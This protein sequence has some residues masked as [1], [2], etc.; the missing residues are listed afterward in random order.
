MKLKSLLREQNLETLREIAAFWEIHPPQESQT[1]GG[2]ESREAQADEGPVSTIDAQALRDH[3]Y[4]RLQSSAHFQQAFE[5]L[6]KAQADIVY[7]LAIHGGNLAH[8]E[9]RRRCFA[10]SSA[11]EMCE[12]M[13]QLQRRG[14]VFR[15]EWADVEGKPVVYGLPE[16]YLKLIDLPHFWRGHLGRLLRN[17]PSEQLGRI[18][19][20]GL[21]L[22]K[23]H[24][25]R[26]RLIH[27]IRTALTDPDRLR[28]YVDALSEEER[29]VLFLILQRRGVC[30]Y[31]ELVDLVQRRRPETARAEALGHLVD[32][33]GLLFDSTHKSSKYQNLLRVPRDLYYIMMNHFERDQRGLHDLDAIGR[34]RPEE[35][36]RTILDNGIAILRDLV[37][38]VGYVE[39]H[40]VR[41]LGNGGI[42]KNDLKKILSRLSAHKTL[43]YAQ[44]LA[45]YAIRH[46]FLVPTGDHFSVTE[47]FRRSL[48][49]SRAFYADIYTSW[50][51]GTEWNEEYVEGDCVHADAPPGNLIHI[52]ALRR[53]VLRNL[54]EIPFEAWIDGPRF[55]ESLLAQI[56]V[57]IPHRGGKARKDKQNRIN[58]LVIESILCE[59]L[60]WM[61]L[62]SLGLHEETRLEQ[63]GNRREV[64][65]IDKNGSRS[66]HDQ[67]FNYNPR[68]LLPEAYRFHFQINGLGRSILGCGTEQSREVLAESE[69]LNL[70]FRDDMVQFTVLPNLDVVAP[71]DLNLERF[72]RLRQFAEVRHIDVMSIMAITRNSVRAAMDHGMSAE[73]IL[74][75]LDASCPSG[76]PQTVRH[77]VDECNMRYGEVTLGYAGGYI[78]VSDVVRLE[79]LRKN[80]TLTPHIKDIIDDRV[81]L[82]TRD[83][84]VPHIARELKKMGMMPALD[85]QNVYKTSEGRLHFSLNADD[86][87]AL[88]AVVKFAVR[89][90]E[91]MDADLT[92]G[93]ARPLLHSLAP[94]SQGHLNVQETQEKM[95]ERFAANFEAGL[96][97]KTD[98][99]T[100]KY[101]SQMRQ[102]LSNHSPSGERHPY[103]GV[104]PATRRADIRKLIHFAIDR[105]T[106]V[107][108]RYLS[109]TKEETVEEVRPESI[110]GDR[111]HAFCES[112][113]AYC[114]YRLSRIQWASID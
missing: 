62:I 16:P 73:D 74:E 70:P 75:F 97:K 38:F 27:E 56:E 30:L 82:L 28:G 78:R 9:L 71:P 80:K 21:N 95:A 34:V 66:R 3:L 81:V 12:A 79:D 61:G 108:L 15:E 90:E 92:E 59:S 29:E 4:P 52:R 19:S 1:Q 113:Q 36:P 46:R 88:M 32:A 91:T 85:N 67:H 114:G 53:L 43:K 102:F 33:S 58:Y 84:D 103:E 50:R 110:N 31:R 40:A 76:L 112:R 25:K 69:D 105:E 17:M 35:Q 94:A 89:V 22:K 44:F 109:T 20:N 24:A 37:I 86:F 68:P 83:A 41:R 72:F 55:I 106:V 42:G 14:F 39:R 96:K 2:S 8:D 49:D 104:N 57:E 93:R 11:E 77:L 5:K 23:T 100:E 7:F 101:R 10:Q 107:R 6:D 51:D 60:Y 45:H 26:D 18:A 13:A 87:A 98:V 47:I 99:L 65:V 64:N 54:A 63:L 111:V 48:A